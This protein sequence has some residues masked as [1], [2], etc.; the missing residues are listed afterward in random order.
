MLKGI[1]P[2]V[3]G[4]GK[5]ERGFVH[6]DEAITRMLELVENRSTGTYDIEGKSISFNKI[7]ANLNKEFGT[8]LKPRY[9]KAPKGYSLT[10]P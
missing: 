4:D 1:R 5:Q 2:V 7:I 8:N 9:V 3:Y 6:V 10:S